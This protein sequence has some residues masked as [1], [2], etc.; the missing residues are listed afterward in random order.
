MAA[1][2][3]A[4][5]AAQVQSLLSLLN[6]ND[7]AFSHMASG[8]DGDTP[9]APPAWK[10]LVMDQTSTDILVTSLSV[11]VL[12]EHGVTLFPQ[13]HSDRPPL[14]DVPAV[15]FVSPTQE[16]IARIV[17]DIGNGVYDAYYLNFTSALP[18]ALLDE[19][20]AGVARTGN[21]AQVR[22]VYD[23]YLDYIVL[24]ANLFQLLPQSQKSTNPRHATAYGRLHDPVLGQ[25]H[26]EAET[27]RIAGGLLSVLATLGTVPIIRAPRGSAAELVAHKLESK[28][29][30]QLSGARSAN[31]L[32]SG[33]DSGSAW[34][35]SRPVLVLLD[36][37]VDLVPMIAHS[38]TYQALV[39]DVLETKLNRVTVTDSGKRSRYDMDAKDYFW[40]QNALAP[41]PQVAENIDDELNRYR[42]EANEIM[43]STGVNN[44]DEVGQLDAT[45][46]AAHLK[47]AVTALPKLTAR[48]KT[49]DAHMNIATAL[50]QGIKTRGLDTLYQLE[51]GISRQS[52]SAILEALKGTEISSADD[53]LRLFL[54]YYLSTPS[55]ENAA[56]FEQILASQGAPLAALAYVKRIRELSR[57]TMMATAPAP[58][59]SGELFKGFSSFG[60]KLTDRLKDSRLEGLVA[61]VKNFLPAQKDLAATRL[62]ASI[63]DPATGSTQALQETDDYL[64]IDPRQPRSRG[65]AMAPG[66]AKARRTYAH[67]I[68]FVVGGGS[69]IEYANLQ[70]YVQRV[71][72]SASSTGAGAS[73]ARR[74]TY[75][76]TEILTPAAF[77]A[78]LAALGSEQ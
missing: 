5:R 49:I 51:E 77:L 32:F 58:A 71:S 3:G 11:P 65:T 36:R 61:G 67:A 66:G 9:S 57:L 42:T 48:K 56:E 55:H 64:Y 4:L 38:W 7:P 72:A 1:P 31:G 43:R 44:I 25:E 14:P 10:V 20:A 59:P 78:T 35:A 26:A 8:A 33:G 75:G 40:E 28:L 62:V 53:K 70:D 22:Q 45:T 15:Y 54:V 73:G 52:R 34:G 41:F 74:I 16:N 27:D 17:K 63:M 68:V 21:G 60:S 6:Y 13:L 46:N 30:E 23:Q 76:S 12:R 39:Y 24:A 18:R 50:L 69:H 2:P 29:R 37:S 47:A 19:L